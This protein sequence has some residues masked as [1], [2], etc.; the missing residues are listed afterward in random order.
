MKWCDNYVRKNNHYFQVILAQAN[1]YVINEIGYGKYI[2]VHISI[3][4]NSVYDDCIWY[5]TLNYIKISMKQC[6]LRKVYIWRIYLMIVIGIIDIYISG[7][8]IMN[9]I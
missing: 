2:N 6:V 8:D 7:I 1:D 9:R 4:T 5:N 3:I